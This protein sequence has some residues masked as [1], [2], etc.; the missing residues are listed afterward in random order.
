VAEFDEEAANKVLAELAATSALDT[1]GD[2]ADG[3]AAVAAAWDAYRTGPAYPTKTSRI[4]SVVD[5]RGASVAKSVKAI[6]AVAPDD[7]AGAVDAARHILGDLF[8]RNGPAETGVFDAVERLRYLAM[9]RPQQ[10]RDA[11]TIMRRR[12]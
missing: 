9:T 6:Q 10:I 4:R 8:T 2:I 1:A 7:V 11:R 5:A 3:I 12:P